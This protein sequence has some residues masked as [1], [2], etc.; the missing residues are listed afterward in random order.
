MGGPQIKS[1]CEHLKWGLEDPCLVDRERRKE[2]FRQRNRVWQGGGTGG[3]GGPDHSHQEGEG[4]AGGKDLQRKRGRLSK[5]RRRE[6]VGSQQAGT[7]LGEAVINNRCHGQG[8]ATGSGTWR[9]ERVWA[10]AFSSMYRGAQVGEQNPVVLQA[11]C[12]VMT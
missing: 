12:L 8:T 6:T 10:S 11:E 7:R 2:D 5:R 9:L 1:L 4:T 3:E